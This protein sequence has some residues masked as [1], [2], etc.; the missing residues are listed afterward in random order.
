LSFSSGFFGPSFAEKLYYLVVKRN[1]ARQ[2]I[3]QIISAFANEENIIADSNTNHLY[4][5]AAVCTPLID[6]SNFA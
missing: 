2:I 1:V 4:V 6:S 5:D 3:W